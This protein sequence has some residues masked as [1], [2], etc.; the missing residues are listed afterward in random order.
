MSKKILYLF[1]DTGGGHRASTNALIAA[2]AKINPKVQQE[3]IDIFAETS[4]F[5]N[6]FARMYG[7]FIRRY[8]KVW[9]ILYYF[10]NDQKNIERLEK[11]ASPLIVDEL[12]ERIKLIDP[13]I[14]VSVHPLA[15]HVTITS[16][17]KAGKNIP[18]ITVVTDPVTFHKTWVCNEVDAL[19]V[20]T[21]EAQNIALDYGMPKNKIKLLGLPINPRFLERQNKKV[22]RRKLGLKENLF[23]VLFM[24]GGEGGGD[25]DKIIKDVNRNLTGIQIIVIC[26]RNQPLQ[27]KLEK[28]KYNFPAKIFGFTFDIPIIMDAADLVVTKAG[29]GSIAEAMAKGLPMILTS[30]LPGQEEGNVE[31]VRSN[32]IGYVEKNPAK[33]A[34]LIKEMMNPK[35]ISQ[36][37][38]KIKKIAKPH[39]SLDIAKFILSYLK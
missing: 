7:P 33:I 11:T 39:A 28:L 6:F 14:I 32:Q 5:L 36:I 10:I 19:V 9:G 12:A 2:V 4:K 38:N 23:T 30:W 1:S 26:G 35:K 24:G 27:T 37:T 31:Y 17:R 13:D 20:A 18:L 8:P 25:M 29:P 21:K 3:M 15:N 34:G 16:I 22:V